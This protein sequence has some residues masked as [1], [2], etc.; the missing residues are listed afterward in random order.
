MKYILPPTIAAGVTFERCVTLADYPAPT[1]TLTAHLRG[2]EVIDI[3]ADADG[4]G[5]KF[6]ELAT[7]TGAWVAGVYQYVIRA[8]NGGDVRQVEAGQVEILADLAAIDTT[9]DLRTHA[10]RAL[11][12]IEAV[13][14]RRATLDQERYRIND[15]ELYRTPLGDLMKL[16]DYYRAEVRREDAAA[17]GKSLWGPAVRVRF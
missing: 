5:H 12:A 3:E 14:E 13:L 9:A 10:R 17:R 1:W 16:R 2:G 15:R 4:T 6:S 11:D 8:T 7:A